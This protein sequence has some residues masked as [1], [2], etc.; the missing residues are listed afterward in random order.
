MQYTKG[1][2]TQEHI[3]QIGKE[4]MYKNGYKNTTISMIVDAAD[5]PHGLVNYYYKKPDFAARLYLEYFSSIDRLLNALIP[6][7]IEN[8]LQFHILQMKIALTQIFKDA[9][10]KAFY[11]EV[12][13]LNLAPKELHDSIRSLQV[14][15][16]H[17]LNTVMNPDDYYLCA[18]AEYG[19]HKVLLDQL[20]EFK[21]TDDRF[22]RIVELI[23]TI[24]VRI[25]GLDPLIIE[26]NILTT[27]TLFDQLD[28]SNIHMF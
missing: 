2:Q 18:I 24:S 3:F 6:T 19:A 26:K 13:R 17:H 16:L 9:K 20:A 10:A 11:Y 28:Y 12:S 4:L 8:E 15:A 21:E 14:S 7:H 27:R 22:E 5:V 23:S 25:A 1:I